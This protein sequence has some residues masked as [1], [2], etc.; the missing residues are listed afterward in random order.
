MTRSLLYIMS[1][2]L[3]GV[4]NCAK[5]SPP[6]LLDASGVVVGKETLWSIPLTESKRDLIYTVLR[7]GVV[8]DGKVL[9]PQHMAAGESL[10]MLSAYT[11]ERLWTWNDMTDLDKVGIYIPSHYVHENLLVFPAGKGE[12]Y[13][14]DLD[15]GSTAA[16]H[17]LPS[18]FLFMI[19]GIGIQY[20]IN[21]E[22]VA[23]DK[24]SEGVVFRG[25][26]GQ[27]QP[28]RLFTPP[29][30]RDTVGRR[31]A[32]GTVSQAVPFM[33]AQGNTLLTFCYSDPQGNFKNNL[34]SG[35]YNMSADSFVYTGQVFSEFA[36]YEANGGL[37]VYQDRAF[38][39]FENEIVCYD[40]YDG[41]V[42]WR[43]PFDNSFT[44]SGYI[45]ADGVLLANNEDT[46]LYGIDPATGRELWKEKSSGTSSHLV[47]H[48]GIVYFV[49]GG[50]GL[51]H[52]V[53]IATGK[54]VWKIRSPDEEK[55]SGAFF[56]PFVAIV[57][58]AS[59]GEKALVVVNSYIG[60]M[61]FEA[62]R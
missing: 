56:M 45:V 11:G 28:T 6:E 15:D 5:D 60:A 7:N 4:T 8:H 27:G 61:A 13:T 23:S 42:L 20:F 38:A 33:D 12:I 59:G 34:S 52:A 47:A 30:L 40:L 46:Y 35:L 14:I 58:P 18:S 49:G 48:N 53:E 36:E 32:Y 57:P 37:E 21:S 54:H 1:L 9:V 19:D 55:N 44:F 10:A 50:D 41:T 51:L 31:D 43:K 24:T 26:L 22:V 25:T 3:F 62:V 17:V 2:T 29:F 39:S 16:K